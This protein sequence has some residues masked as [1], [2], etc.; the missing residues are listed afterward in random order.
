MSPAGHMG[1]G[2]GASGCVGWE[3]G[4]LCLRDSQGHPLGPLAAGHGQGL[5]EVWG[6]KLGPRDHVTSWGQNC[7]A[8][9]AQ[10]CCEVAIPVTAWGPDLAHPSFPTPKFW[11]PRLI[12]TCREGRRW[13]GRGGGWDAGGLASQEASSPSLQSYALTVYTTNLCTDCLHLTNKH[14]L[15]TVTWPHWADALWTDSRS[16]PCCQEVGKAHLVT[17][18][19]WPGLTCVTWLVRLTTASAHW[20]LLGFGL[21]NNSHQGEVSVDGD[22]A[23]AQP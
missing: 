15:S 3:S 6:L 23:G 17:C 8:Q 13:T 1:V 19:T 11:G 2:Q 5:L 10:D 12:F 22:R 9:V 14:H 7:R 16:L 18:L 4:P 21:E 20:H